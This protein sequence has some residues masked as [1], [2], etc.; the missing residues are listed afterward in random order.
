MYRRYVNEDSIFWAVERNAK[1]V[2]PG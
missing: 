1:D 2:L